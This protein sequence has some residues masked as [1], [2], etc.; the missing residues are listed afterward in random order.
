MLNHPPSIQQIFLKVKWIFHCE[1]P[2][3]CIQE[4]MNYIY[5]DCEFQITWPQP[6]LFQ[7]SK[8]FFVNDSTTQ[9]YN[10]HQHEKFLIL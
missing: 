9:A 7:L 10:I 6:I 2:V 4:L 8:D 1:L 5:K 3:P